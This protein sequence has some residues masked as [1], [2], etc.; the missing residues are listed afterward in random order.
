MRAARPTRPRARYVVVAAAAPIALA[1]AVRRL[2][3]NSACAQP[4]ALTTFIA[5]RNR[6][7][8]DGITPLAA[9][10]AA[11]GT[12]KVIRVFQNGIN[13]EGII[14][15]AE[16]LG[17]NTDLEVLDVND[18]TVKA[19]GSK[20]IAAV[21][22]K[23]T[24]LKTLDVGDC[25]M[26]NEGV[27]ALAEALENSCPDLEVLNLVFNEIED[28][29]AIALAKALANK[30]KLKTLE[31]DGNEIHSA[32]LDAI[33]SVLAALGVPDALGSMEDNEGSDDEDDWSGDDD[34]DDDVN[35]LAKDVAAVKVE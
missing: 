12:M 17:A 8:N 35:N 18:N 6:L 19:E 4:A 26:T 11:M 2:T 7:E 10:F 28:D 15:L 30:T 31:L 21:L 14:A 13:K 33:K 23:L 20:A 22:P 32:G 16:A 24:K 29:G 27:L 9:S 5:G 25:L 1:P 34:D 3:T